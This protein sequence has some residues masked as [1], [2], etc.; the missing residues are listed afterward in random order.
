MIFTLFLYQYIYSLESLAPLYFLCDSSII[1]RWW[2]VRLSFLILCFFFL[3]YYTGWNV[4]YNQESFPF[5]KRKAF[6]IS[7]LGMFSNTSFE[8]IDTIN[9]GEIHCFSNV[10]ATLWFW[11]KTNSATIY[12]PFLYIGRSKFITFYWIFIMYINEI[13]L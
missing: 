9:G 11:D 8:T 10:R 12:Y 7:S 5:T 4:Q 6:K 2:K 13:V 3:D 1:G